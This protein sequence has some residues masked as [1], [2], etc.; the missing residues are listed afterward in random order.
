MINTLSAERGNARDYLLTEEG[1]YQLEIL[2]ANQLMVLGVW[3]L[4]ILVPAVALTFSD[5]IVYL[6][7]TLAFLVA[8]VV[9]GRLTRALARSKRKALY[10]R[11]SSGTYRLEPEH[12]TPWSKISSVVLSH[13]DI[14]MTL[15]GKR[16]LG[17]IQ[18][19]DFGRLREL[20]A[21]KTEGRFVVQE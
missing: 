8:M 19:S 3:L 2:R 15:D 10:S 13:K 20:I 11:L 16:G 5:Q 7:L 21:P 9:S 18:P 14:R 4:V 12:L 6:F 17:R 1:V